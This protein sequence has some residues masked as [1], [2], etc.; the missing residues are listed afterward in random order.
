MQRSTTLEKQ[1][2]RNVDAS[3]R[4]HAS[5]PV[6]SEV[7]LLNSLRNLTYQT[8]VVSHAWD[9]N[10]HASSIAEEFVFDRMY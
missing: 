9:A 10:S 2:S 1:S 7:R 8:P 4:L 6:T 3:G 5:P